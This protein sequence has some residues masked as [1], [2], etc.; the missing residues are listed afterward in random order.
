[1]IQEEQIQT[2]MDFG[3]T[4]LQAKTYLALAQLGKADVKTIAKAS[5]VARQDIYRIMPTLQKLGLGEKII[6]KP[7]LYKATPIKEGVSILLQNIE[8]EHAELQEKT[9]SLIDTFQEKNAKIFLQEDSTQF[10]ITSEITRFL[11]IHKNQAQ[12]AQESIDIMIPVMS[13]PSKLSEEW[14]YFERSLKRGVKIRLLAQKPGEGFPVIEW[15]ALAKSPFFELKYSAITILFGMFIFDNKEV[16]LQ[17]S[18]D[19]LP[20]L[21]SNN[22]NVVKLASSYFNEVWNKT[23]ENWAKESPNQIQQ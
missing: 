6:A 19:I 17:V 16:T 13:V 15:Q 2:L 1:M 8:K 10:T 9:T 12:K 11:K 3:L 18:E 22:P 14:R 7:T 5:N 20:S 21:W 23:E 4:S